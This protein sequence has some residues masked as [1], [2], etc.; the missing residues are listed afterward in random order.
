MFRATAMFVQG[1]GLAILL[2][3]G[4]SYLSGREASGARV[5][6]AVA[7]AASIA[8]AFAGVDLVAA[9]AVA[10]GTG[11]ALGALSR[12]PV[13]AAWFAV[14]GFAAAVAAA[15]LGARSAC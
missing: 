7:F 6:G 10:S 3:S 1:C 11:A 13:P 5:G 4:R 9:L 15:V 12:K 14:A 2:R 8:V